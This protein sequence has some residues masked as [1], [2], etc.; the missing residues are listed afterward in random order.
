[1]REFFTSPLFFTVMG[2]FII[3]YLYQILIAG[4]READRNKRVTEYTG[5]LSE[6]A[7]SRIEDTLRQKDKNSAIQIFRD[8]TDVGQSEAK[9][10]IN[11]IIREMRKKK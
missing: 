6:D 10:S 2:G 4:P 9:E 1:M 11:F 7:L 5:R 3:S 8:E